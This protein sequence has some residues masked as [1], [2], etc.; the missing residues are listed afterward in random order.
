M[1]IYHNGQ[2]EQFLLL[3]SML[4]LICAYFTCIE[5]SVHC[6]DHLMQIKAV[7]NMILPFMFDCIYSLLEKRKY[8]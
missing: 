8:I 6:I 5:I 2:L 3:F 1:P 7:M 4:R